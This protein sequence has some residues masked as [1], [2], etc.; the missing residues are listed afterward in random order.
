[1]VEERHRQ[2]ADDAGHDQRNA[3]TFARG[4][5]RNGTEPAETQAIGQ[6]SFRSYLSAI[7][8]SPHF[9]PTQVKC[10]TDPRRPAITDR[11]L[12]TYSIKSRGGPYDQRIIKSVSAGPR[13]RAR[14]EARPMKEITGGL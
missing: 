9:S 7:R 14:T 10:S 8:V 1:M 6:E 13:G 2:L 5:V 12:L 11:L 3:E 4:P